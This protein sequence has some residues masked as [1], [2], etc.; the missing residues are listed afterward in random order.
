VGD[1]HTRWDAQR[2]DGSPPS[3]LQRSTE[4]LSADETVYAGASFEEYYALERLEYPLMTKRTAAHNS[5]V[6]RFREL[7]PTL[8]D[9]LSKEEQP[10]LVSM[11]KKARKSCADAFGL[12]DEREAGPVER[13]GEVCV[14]V[15]AVVVPS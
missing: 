5:K 15:D 3:L 1:V 10:A 7:A 14:V 8:P 11:R 6:A 9:V 12:E 2:S 4:W 13:A